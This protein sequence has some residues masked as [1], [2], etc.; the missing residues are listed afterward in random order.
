MKKK[1]DSDDDATSN[2]KSNI[3]PS[4]PPKQRE[5][6]VHKDDISVDF[7][8]SVNEMF[9][10]KKQEAQFEPLPTV[11]PSLQSNHDLMAIKGFF[12]HIRNSLSENYGKYSKFSCWLVI[13]INVSQP[14]VFTYF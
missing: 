5:Q 1:E 10:R 11:L 13:V 9:A 6:S 4:T 7:S 3:R 8:K 14:I 2:S 12:D